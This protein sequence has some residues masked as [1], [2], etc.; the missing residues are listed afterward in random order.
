M[1]SSSETLP[2]VITVALHQCHA[3]PCRHGLPLVIRNDYKSFGMNINNPTP[4]TYLHT[5]FFTYPLACLLTYLLT[6]PLTHWHTTPTYY[7]PS[8]L[9]NIYLLIHPP[10][11]LLTHPSTYLPTY[12]IFFITYKIPTSYLSSYNLSITYIIV[13]YWYEI[14]MWNKKKLTK[15][16]HLLML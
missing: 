11:Y 15:N 9:P 12:F 8:H 7:L 4:T 2:T 14:N 3:V 6:Y 10:T 16:G 5:Y 13:L 1:W